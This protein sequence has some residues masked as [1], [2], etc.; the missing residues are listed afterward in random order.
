MNRVEVKPELL[1]WARARAALSIDALVDRF[2]R[3][4]DWEREK[5]YP[6]F[7]QLEKFAKATYT[8]VGFLFLQEPPVEHIPIPDFR[9]IA[10]ANINSPSANL[11]DTIYLCQQR[12][13]WYREFALTTGEKPLRVVGSASITDNPIAVAARIR[14]SLDF[15]VAKRRN[16]STWTEALRQFISQ[17]DEMGILVMVS[18]V[19]GNN[20]HRKLDPEEFRGFALSDSIAPVIFINGAD[21]KAAQMFTLAHELA[22]IW[23]GESGISDTPVRD[24]SDHET[25]NWCNRVAAELLVPADLLHVEYN[26]KARLQD[27]LNR[28]ARHFKV[29]T[30]VI[31]RRIHDMGGLTQ[32]IFRAA[33]QEELNRLKSLPAGGGG[34][35]YL[36]LSAR[37]SQ[38]FTRAII[39][40]ALEGQTS[41]TDSFRLLG[42]RKMAT[43]D[44]LANKLGMK[45]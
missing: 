19:V 42:F 21:T 15:D 10:N 7:K 16:L 31:L 2:P 27:E 9:T 14:Q 41:F 32:E 6:T 28:L 20:N 5:I 1:R 11:L 26:R 36:S 13:N 3:I 23:L 40:S 33:Y 38:R 8:P 25:E 45:F 34:N 17:I 4:E 30:L 12:Q 43:F 37:A 22:H 29:S 18:G 35:F 24:R 44:R 39:A